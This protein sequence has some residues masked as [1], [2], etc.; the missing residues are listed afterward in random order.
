MSQM[1]PAK[2]TAIPPTWLRRIETPKTAI[3]M[4]NVQIGLSAFNIPAIALGRAVCAEAK[5]IAGMKLPTDPMRLTQSHCSRFSFRQCLSATGIKVNPAIAIR[6]AASS[7][8]GNKEDPSDANRPHFMS[9]K[10]LPQTKPSSNRT[11]MGAHFGLV[12]NWVFITSEIRL[13]WVSAVDD[14]CIFV[15]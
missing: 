12:D 4:S 13:C 14:H 7:V 5:R 1:V 8:G 2:P 15:A 6:S 10:L 9:M 3:P 11:N